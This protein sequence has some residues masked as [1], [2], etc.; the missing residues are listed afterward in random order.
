[1]RIVYTVAGL[2]P[3]FGG[4]SRSVPALAGAV[5]AK[6]AT[7]TVVSL[8]EPRDREAVQPARQREIQWVPAYHRYLPLGWIASF[9]KTVREELAADKASVL[10]DAGLWLPSNRIAASVAR[11]SAVPL[12]VSPRG[13]LSTWSLQQRSLAKRLAW[14]WHQRRDLQGATLLHATADTEAE[15]FRRAGLTAPVAVVPNGVDLPEIG[16]LNRGREKFVLFLSRIHPKKGVLDLVA[17]WAAVRPNGWRLRIAGND[18]AGHEATVRDAVLRAGIGDAVDF[19][20]PLD[21]SKKG[22]EFARASLFVLP[23]YSEN[24]GIAIA[25]ALAAGVP[26]IT[27]RETPWEWLIE[28]NCGWW[29]ETGVP[30]LTLTLRGATEGP[31]AE[32]GEMG[33]R[34]REWMREEFSWEE[35]ARKML[36]CYRWLVGKGDRPAFVHD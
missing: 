21:D 36:D 22:Q 20:G 30:A 28:K 31:M 14:Q 2:A 17:A 10:H 24:F 1:M 35:A 34:G 25:E 11:A 27:T 33:R 7:T 5:R 12:V 9:R 15:E 16:A 23:S 32:L 26:V 29:I 18:E 4:P 13:M 8:L 6:G 3:R 19:L